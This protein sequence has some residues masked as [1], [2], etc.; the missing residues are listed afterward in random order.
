M[1]IEQSEFILSTDGAAGTADADT[2]IKV[3]EELTN[4]GS[5]NPS[6]CLSDK[7]LEGSFLDM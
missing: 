7:S 3:I 2:N 1:N 5:A 6:R 4:E